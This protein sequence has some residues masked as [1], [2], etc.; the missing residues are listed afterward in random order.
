M[1]VIVPIAMCIDVIQVRLHNFTPIFVSTTRASVAQ[2]QHNNTALHQHGAEQPKL[3][4]H[5]LFHQLNT[6][7]KYVVTIATLCSITALP[8]CTVCAM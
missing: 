4:A 5:S 2:Y 6:M 7:H 8:A 3:F 1:I